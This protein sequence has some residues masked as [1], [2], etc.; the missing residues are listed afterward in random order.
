MEAGGT[1]IF[2]TVVEDDG[3][4]AWTQVTPKGWWFLNIADFERTRSFVVHFSVE[5]QSEQCTQIQRGDTPDPRNTVFS[6]GMAHR[7]TPM[8]SAW[9]TVQVATPPAPP[10]L[11]AN[12]RF[13]QTQRETRWFDPPDSLPEGVRG[14]LGPTLYRGDQLR[15]E[16]KWLGRLPDVLDHS[17]TMDFERF[18]HNERI[19]LASLAPG[20]H[21]VDVEAKLKGGDTRSYHIMFSVVNKVDLLIDNPMIDI[22]IEVGKPNG[23]RIPIRVRNNTAH[24][25]P[26]IV[27]VSGAPVGWK[28]LVNDGLIHRLAPNSEKKLTLQFEMMNDSGASKEFMPITVSTSTNLRASLTDRSKPEHL[29]SATAYVRPVIATELMKRMQRSKSAMQKSQ[30][31][32]AF[33]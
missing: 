10:G 29:V 13:W 2:D 1:R 28:A 16:T 14:L 9:Q 17:I 6:G 31:P 30:P 33:G 25:M 12:E 24:E 18:R 23:A 21:F 4:S 32:I 5:Y 19:D 15:I 8:N 27:R 26:V 20:H 11:P 22:P 7:A 3:W